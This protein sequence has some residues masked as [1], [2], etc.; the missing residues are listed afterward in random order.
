MKNTWSILKILIS[1]PKAG[2]ASDVFLINQQTV[3]DPK[4]IADGFNN[5]FVNVGPNLASQIPDLPI[6]HHDY[7]PECNLDNMFLMP[8]VEK[9]LLDITNAFVIK[10]SVGADD[11]SSRVIKDTITSISAPLCDI[12]NKSYSTGCFPDQ[13]KIAKVIPIFKNDNPQL[14][15]NYR[16]ISVL[17]FFSK[18]LERLT[19]NRLKSFIWRHLSNNQFGFRDKYSTYMALTLLYDKIS[20]N[21]ESGNPSVG[22][23]LDLSKAFDTINH[24]ILL[25]KLNNYGIRGL[26]NDW[27]RSYLSGRLQFVKF[28]DINSSYLEVTCGVP[29]GSILGPLLFILYINDISNSSNILNFILFADDTN[30]FH[31][32]PNPVSLSNTVNTELQKVM[33]WF[34]VNKLSINLKK[35]HYMV[36]GPN[37]KSDLV[38]LNSISRVTVTK[39]LGVLIDRNLT[40]HD[41]ILNVVKKVSKAIGILSR[42]RRLLPTS[43]LTTIYSSIVLPHLQYCNI[44]WGNTY[45]TRLEPLYLLQKRAMRIIHNSDFRAHSAPLFRISKQLNIYDINIHQTASFMFQFI[46]NTLPPGLEFSFISRTNFHRYATRSTDDFIIPH[47]STRLRSF[48]IS[49][50]GPKIW[51]SLD[52]AI[53]QLPDIKS[54]R[55]KFKLSMYSRY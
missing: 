12:F 16:P 15:N 37:A 30:V 34:A 9:E 42:I 5:Y 45:P 3:S 44:V 7:M 49:V 19:Y 25:S 18:L 10:R 6:S 11:L 4:T 1:S 24:E 23:F 35:T 55:K 20:K 36:F 8:I 31:S 14:F 41:Q 29:Q 53:K 50:S 38:H 40:W 26:A 47:H 46:N 43:A 32:D 13:L 2:I 28:K 33:K 17:N 27:F 51:N 54:F 48:A 22:I 39:F 52:S 21:C